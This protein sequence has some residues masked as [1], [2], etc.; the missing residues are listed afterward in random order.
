MRE[1]RTILHIAYGVSSLCLALLLSGCAS[2]PNLLPTT[3]VVIACPPELQ[4]RP[5]R[6]FPPIPEVFTN[7]SLEEFVLSLIVQ[8]RQE[9]KAIDQARSDCETWLRGQGWKP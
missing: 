5:L 3:R 9:W 1:R 7:G 8:M 6:Q 4:Y 2:M